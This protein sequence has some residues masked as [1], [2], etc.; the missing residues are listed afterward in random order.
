[1]ARRAR[2]SALPAGSGTGAGFDRFDT[3][4]GQLIGG[5]DLN[6]PLTDGIEAAE[7]DMSA[8]FGQ[9]ANSLRHEETAVGDVAC[10]QRSEDSPDPLCDNDQP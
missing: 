2:G 10:P 6:A 9:R 3:T 8:P 7:S 4:P 5:D 1:V